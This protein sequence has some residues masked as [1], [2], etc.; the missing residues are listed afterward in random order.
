MHCTKVTYIPA[1]AG[2]IDILQAPLPWVR[3][4]L[5]DSGLY[6]KLDGRENEMLIPAC[7]TCNLIFGGVREQDEETLWSWSR[8]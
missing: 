5:L 6:R 7:K 1:G 4:L 2:I 3:K 8:W